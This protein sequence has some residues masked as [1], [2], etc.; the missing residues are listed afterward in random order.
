MW[1]QLKQFPGFFPVTRCRF[2]LRNH[3]VESNL[4]ILPDFFCRGA[5]H[6]AGHTGRPWTDRL[7]GLGWVL[8]NRATESVRSRLLEM[9]NATVLLVVTTS[10]LWIS[11]SASMSN[12]MSLSSHMSGFTFGFAAIFFFL[13]LLSLFRSFDLTAIFPTSTTILPA[14]AS[15]TDIF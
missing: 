11:Y 1:E 6:R 8:N 14:F 10:V 5:P 15:G 12:R 2:Y 13:S 9:D 7:G 4:P 3:Y